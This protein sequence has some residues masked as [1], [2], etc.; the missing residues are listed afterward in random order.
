MEAHSSRAGAGALSRAAPVP[1]RP[2]R[3]RDDRLLPVAHRGRQPPARRRHH[4]LPPALVR[5]PGRRLRR[6][7]RHRPAAAR[8]H[9]APGRAHRDQRNRPAARAPRA[10][11]EA[12]GARRSARPSPAGAAPPG[13]GSPALSPST[14]P[15]TSGAC[16]RHR[17][18]LG[19]AIQIDLTAAP[20]IIAASRNASRLAREHGITMLVLAEATAR[21]KAAAG[22]PPGDAPPRSPWPSPGLDPGHPDTAEAAAY[23]ETIKMA[24]AILSTPRRRAGITGKTLPAAPGGPT[25]LSQQ[26]PHFCHLKRPAQVRWGGPGRFICHRTLPEVRHLNLRRTGPGEGRV[27]RDDRLR[28]ARR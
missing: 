12:A 5:R 16:Q 13:T 2:A 1:H 14:S 26:Q 3:R 15:L 7:R 11:R 17:T 22:R 18:W 6:P 28:P 9:P 20:D 27:S 21:E 24:A 19:R 10:R 4:R 23:P 8:R 25:Y